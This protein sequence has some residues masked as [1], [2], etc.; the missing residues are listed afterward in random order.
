[1]SNPVLR[2]STSNPVQRMACYLA[3]ASSQ[4][5]EP[6]TKYNQAIPEIK[7]L[8]LAN[9]E[10][11]EFDHLP[12]VQTVSD[13]VAQKMDYSEPVECTA[14]R[15]SRSNPE[16]DTAPYVQLVDG[17]HRYAAA[18]QTGRKWLPVTI[19]ARNAKGIKL[20]KLIKLSQEIAHHHHLTTA[21]V[22]RIEIGKF[23]SYPPD[24]YNP[25][26]YVLVWPLAKNKGSGFTAVKIEMYNGKVVRPAKY[27][28]DDSKHS[29]AILTE[30]P[31]DKVP[32]KALAKFVEKAK[33]LNLPFTDPSLVTAAVKKP[34]KIEISPIVYEQK[35]EKIQETWFRM[36]NAADYAHTERQRTA[37]QNKA[38]AYERKALDELEK[39]YVVV[40]R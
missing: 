10:R 14:F 22:P 2:T 11:Q 25:D 16:D 29:L 34:P 7:Y 4:P 23:Y 20:N 40:Q 19:V 30:V 31:K 26:E 36:F 33:E 35:K 5:Y 28:L 13:D 1:M 3:L 9:I 38:D 32:A 37:M 17:H 24:K 21:A 15:Y 18:L 8:P 27:S 6:D 12:E 39:K